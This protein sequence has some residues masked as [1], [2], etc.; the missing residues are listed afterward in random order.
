MSQK[1]VKYEAPQEQLQTAAEPVLNPLAVVENATTISNELSRIISHANL[2]KSIN[3]RKFVYVE[4]W[5]SMLAMLGVTP[6]VVECVRI[7]RE[8]EIAYRAIVELVDRSDRKLGRGVSMCS[9]KEKLW[10][11]RDEFAI[12]SM[13]Q[14]RAVGKAARLAF[15]WIMTLAGFEATPS[16]E[17]E[18]VEVQKPVVQAQAVKPVGDPV[19]DVPRYDLLVAEITQLE[20]VGNLKQI[21]DWA[22]KVG[23]AKN[24]PADQL[25]ALRKMYVE[26]KKAAE[27]RQAKAVAA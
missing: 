15:S 22:H 27:E 17:M 16:E 4:G 11:N 8:G 12:A 21:D 9:S 6:N 2:F 5:T 26:A 23:N 19:R 24:L 1:V 25:S 10:S 18:S 13:S 20:M 3:G 7:E 14:T